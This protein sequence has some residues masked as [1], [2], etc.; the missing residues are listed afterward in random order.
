[1]GGH[2]YICERPPITD[3]STQSILEEHKGQGVLALLR[4]FVLHAMDSG[5]KEE[6]GNGNKDIF[7][8]ILGG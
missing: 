8:C 5:T 6:E 2:P 1:V 7:L 4:K 3:F